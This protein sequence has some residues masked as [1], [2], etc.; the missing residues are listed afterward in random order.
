MR[1]ITPWD[2]FQDLEQFSHQLSNLFERSALRRDSKDS[3]TVP[4]WS[5]LVDIS[6]DEKEYL[7]KAELPEV[8]KDAVKLT[9]EKGVLTITGERHLEQTDKSARHHRI[10]RFYGKFARSFAVPENADGSGITADFKNGVL[11]VHL[12]KT[13]EAKP[14]Q[15][16]ISVD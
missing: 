9:V 6:E 16:E 14:K 15:I 10:E 1:T 5:P 8:E 4:N 7:I 12:P 11:R 2:P 3:P 13:E